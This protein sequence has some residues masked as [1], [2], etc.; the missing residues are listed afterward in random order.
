[1][2]ALKITNYFIEGLITYPN[3]LCGT[4]QHNCDNRAT[5]MN[6]D[7]GFVCSCPDGFT[8]IDGTKCVDIDECDDSIHDCNSN[9]KCLNTIGSYT[10]EAKG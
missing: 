10:C 7:N 5:C 9:Q 2:K 4:G 8:G 1:M 3:D 6:N